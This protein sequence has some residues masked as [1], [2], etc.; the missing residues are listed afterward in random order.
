MKRLITFLLIVLG[1]IP[2]LYSQVTM[3][4]ASHGF[5]GGQSHEC[6]AV[7]YQSPGES[8]KNCVWDFSKA[9]ALNAA[10][11]T[12]DLS[13]DN[14]TLGTISVTRNDD[15]CE[16]FFTTT[17]SANEYWGYKIGNKIYQL[18]EPIVKTKYPQTYGTQFSGKFAGTISVEGAN[19][20]QK[21]EGDYSTNVDGMGTV[22]LPDNVSLPAIRVKTTESNAS[23]ERVKYLWYAQDVRLP[24]FVSLEDYSIA[25]DGTRKL[26]A[27]ES[28]LNTQ[29]KSQTSAPSSSDAFSYQ[30]SPNPFRDEIQ[31]TYTVTGKNLVTVELYDAAGGTKLATLASQVQSGAQS[32]SKDVSKYAKLPGVY[33]LKIIVGSK[34]YTEKLLKVY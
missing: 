21:V 17:E 3:T 18:T 8:G 12:A 30:V 32:L 19:Y 34:V 28:F 9:T 31:L 26:L 10:K 15:G 5:S 4:K 1:A 6:Q 33:L 14:S 25:A 16:F 23:F 11:S 13:E 7:Q 22:I 29:V 27:E 20:S 2:L 24:L